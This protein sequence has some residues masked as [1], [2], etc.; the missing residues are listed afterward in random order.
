MFG[1]LFYRHQQ[2]NDSHNLKTPRNQRGPASAGGTNDSATQTWE[3]SH[4][5]FLRGRPD[6]LEAIKRKALEPDPASKAR[7]ELPGEVAAQ[8]AHMRENQRRVVKAL[9][10]ERAKVEKLVGVVRCLSDVVARLC[11]GSGKYKQTKHFQFLSLTI[12]SS[13]PSIPS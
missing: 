11:P 4:Q 8:L 3:F 13:S 1:L 10:V 2:P 7:I 6:L 9:D 12:Y 5:K